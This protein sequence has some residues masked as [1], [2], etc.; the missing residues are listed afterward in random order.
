MR[1]GIVGAGSMGTL[2]AA[3][4]G[5]TD[6]EV[7][8]IAA[9][10]GR[11]PQELAAEVGAEAVDD[12][13]ALLDRVDL[14]DVCVPTDRHLEVVRAAAAAGRH[15]RCEK[16]LARTASEARAAIA[17]C[18]DAEVHLHVGHVVR[19]FPAYAAAHAAVSAGRI[20][21][22]AVLRLRRATYRPLRPADDWFRDPRRSGGLL[23]DLMIHDLDQARWLAGEVTHVYARSLA[24]RRPDTEVDHAVA[25]LTHHDGAISHVEA[26]WAHPPPTFHTALEIAGTDGLLSH[27]SEANEPV[28]IQRA[29]TAAP[30]AVPV[31][32]GDLGTS[33]YTVQLRHLL[34]VLRGEQAPLLTARD[35]L[36]AILIAEA[37]ERSLASGEPEPVE[38]LEPVAT[39]EPN[40]PAVTP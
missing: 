1:I 39:P 11:P 31:P 27:D 35:G 18:E 24:S 6:A 30:T 23:L 14:V 4:W 28:R 26:S 33:P 38:P 37:A 16:P 7:V 12:L 15:V 32:A 3:A 36:A 20:G 19:F 8:A 9:E 10:P 34:A 29:H 5:H 2:H 13:D 40:A 17:A 25:V 21:T 22:P